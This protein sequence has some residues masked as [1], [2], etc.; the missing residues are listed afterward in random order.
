[1]PIY[2]RL[3][4]PTQYGLSTLYNSWL[5]IVLIFATLKLAAGVFNNG[6]VFFPEDRDRFQSS[7]QGLSTTSTLVCIVIY[8]L[9][10]NYFDKW[11]G[12]PRVLIIVMLL[13]SMFMPAFN[14]WTARRRYEYKYVGF[15]VSTIGFSIVASVFS[16]VFIF[17]FEDKGTMKI[18]GGAIGSIGIFICFY[19]YNFIKGKSFFNRKYWLYALKFNLPL[20][21]HYLSMIILNQSDRIMIANMCGQEEAGLYGV[22]FNIGKVALLFNSSITAS[23]TPWIYEKIKKKK[24]KGIS[25]ISFSLFLFI[26]A[27]ITGIMLFGPEL[28][29]IFATPEYYQAVYVIPPIAACAYFTFV[30]NQVSAVE[31]F[32]G[33]SQY[34][35]IASVVG[36]VLNIILNYFAILKFGYIS[37]AYVS[38]LCYVLFA[39]CHFCLMKGLCKRNNITEALFSQRKLIILSIIIILVTIFANYIYK[40]YILRYV[41]IG[42][43]AVIAII[44]RN[45]IIQLVK[46]LK[47]K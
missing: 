32:Y 22:A 33:K 41:L 30:Y 16:I 35:M 26:A 39:I 9:F 38:M 5:D 40:Y 27:M 36:A 13:Y 25:E 46:S 29:R 6:M 1:M 11:L 43:V 12:L 28:I 44:K 10:A 34:I 45:D 2:T 20:I 37:A 31:F 14:Y 21:P 42:T 24:F 23:F 8:F 15:T 4:T 18:L 19:I 17:L 3:L 7:M 47:Q